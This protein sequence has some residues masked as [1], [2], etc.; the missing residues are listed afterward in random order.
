MCYPFDQ[1]CAFFSC[2]KEWMDAAKLNVKNAYL[3][4][5]VICEASYAGPLFWVDN[6]P[7][8]TGAKGMAKEKIRHAAH[9]QAKEAATLYIGK[10]LLAHQR[11][12]YVFAPYHSG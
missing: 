2:S 8:F 6:H 11:F 12:Q 10:A 1:T 7:A 4:P 3:D 9:K 5:N